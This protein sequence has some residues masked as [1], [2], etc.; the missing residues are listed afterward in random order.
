L[1]SIWRSFRQGGNTK[2]EDWSLEELA[3]ALGFD[4]EKQV[5][6][7][8]ESYQFRVVEKDGGKKYL[9]LNSVTGK[10][11]PEPTVRIPAQQFSDS[12]VEVKRCGRTLSALVNGLS[13]KAAIQAGMIMNN[14]ET[15]EDQSESS[16]FV[17]GDSDDE[18]ELRFVDG[19]S[20]SMG[21]IDR[22]TMENATSL[23]RTFASAL[24]S[25]SIPTT[26]IET[27]TI[28]EATGNSINTLLMPPSAASAP[29]F[30]FS[31]TPPSQA[32]QTPF[33]VSQ[34]LQNFITAAS[35][36][37]PVTL[38]TSAPSTI[39]TNYTMVNEQGAPAPNQGNNSQQG[40]PTSE[41]FEHRRKKGISIFNR[42]SKLASSL[43]NPRKHH[44]AVPQQQQAALQ[45]Q[46]P[47]PDFQSQLPHIHQALHQQHQSFTP[48]QQAALEQQRPL[49]DFQSQLPQ[50]QQTLQQQQHP[51][52]QQ[53][54]PQPPPQTPL[55]QLSIPPQ[56]Q[57][58]FLPEQIPLPE[59]PP[60][61]Q[62]LEPQQIPLP[63]SP[64]K[65]QRSLPQQQATGSQSGKRKITDRID[66]AI[67]ADAQ[68]QQNTAGPSE[69][70][71]EHRAKRPMFNRLKKS[72]S[73]PESNLPPQQPQSVLQQQ[74]PQS[75]LQ[76][77]QSVLQQQQP[78]SVIQP[79]QSDLQQQQPQ[80]IL[81]QPQSIL[82]QQQ[83]QSVFQPPQSD[84]QQQQQQFVQQPQTDVQ[85]QSFP[86]QQQADPQQ[87]QSVLQQPQS[88][89]QQPQSV[90]Q[91]QQPF[92]QQPFQQQSFQQQPFQ[93]Q[94]FQQQPFQQQPFQQQSF[95]QQPFQQQPFQQQPFQ[96]QPFQQ[97]PFQQQPFQ[98]QPFQQ[99]PFQQQP[100]QQQPFQQQPF[101][102]QPFQQQSSQQQPLQQQPFQQQPFQQQSVL[103]QQP[104]TQD[105]VDVPFE[106]AED[107]PPAPQQRPPPTLVFAHLGAPGSAESLSKYQI[108]PDNIFGY[109]AAPAPPQQ[110]PP[111]QHATYLQDGGLPPQQQPMLNT[112]AP[113][114]T[115]WNQQQQPM[116]N[117]AAPQDAVWNQQ[118][119]PMLNAAAPQDAVWNPQQQQPILNVVAPQDAV[120]NPQQPMLNA[121]APQDVAWN[122]QQQPML[123]AVAPQDTAWNQQQQPMLDAAAPQD[124]V[125]NQQQQPILNAAAP[126]D[127]VW[128]PQQQTSQ[129]QPAPT[130][131]RYDQYQLD[132][133]YAK[134]A[135]A[136]KARK[137]L[138]AEKASREKYKREWME[139]Y[140][141]EK[142]AK[143]KVAAEKAAAAE[144]RRQQRL[145]AEREIKLLHEKYQREKEAAFKIA[146]PMRKDEVQE[147]LGRQ[148][149]LDLSW[150]VLPTYI[151]HVTR[152]LVKQE[153]LDF[154]DEQD[155]QQA[156]EFRRHS[157]AVR[158][159]HRWYRNA[160]SMRLRRRGQLYR[161]RAKE[162]IKQKSQTPDSQNGNEALK[163]DT[164]QA[165]AV[166]IVPSLGQ[167]QIDSSPNNRLQIS[168][169]S[170]PSEDTPSRNERKRKSD[171]Q[172]HGGWA[173]PSA[174]AAAR[175]SSADHKV[176]RMTG[177]VS[178]ALSTAASA[179]SA[180]DATG[181]P[182]I[183]LIRGHPRPD[184][185][186][187]TF[188]NPYFL[189]KSHG[190]YA[191]SRQTLQREVAKRKRATED[192]PNQT[193]QTSCEPDSPPENKRR[194]SETQM[195]HLRSLSS[196]SHNSIQ[197]VVQ[198]F[199]ESESW[200]RRTRD[201]LQQGQGLHGTMSGSSTSPN[202]GAGGQSGPTSPQSVPKYRSRQSK[203]VS[204]KALGGRMMG[205]TTRSREVTTVSRQEE[206]EQMQREEAEVAAALVAANRAENANGHGYSHS[207]RFAALAQDDDAEVVDDE[208]SEEVYGEEYQEMTEAEGE[209]EGEATEDD[210]EIE[211]VATKS[212]YGTGTGATADDAI[213]LDSD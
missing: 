52:Q 96:Q 153:M 212:N 80:S 126:Q 202:A 90:L 4:E 46:H 91:Q 129:V 133:L 1:Q 157:L 55:G 141:A 206:E 174:R 128:N 33:N 186:I 185:K 187:S 168:T 152:Q 100:F 192:D 38:T 211:I 160:R 3:D 86:Q 175:P 159:F 111:T 30:S 76:Q 31:V 200:Y 89:F 104:F 5:Q 16:L 150:G 53:P 73:A 42:M 184:S 6:T 60:R 69:Q 13:T 180:P 207:N 139:R 130:L 112:V 148:M 23:R 127:A 101:Q 9:D 70:S 149:A 67:V 48:Q 75:T 173:Q 32:T 208:E 92:Q 183:D 36:T 176:S 154:E 87:P 151:Y 74:Q 20:A 59:S 107:I 78:Q 120:W 106:N 170:Q 190:I 93:Q 37:S 18:G 161:A 203:F 71:E 156:D 162:I 19:L 43:T 204:T 194:A 50:I 113:Q 119:Q 94:P 143:E 35:G 108:R 121:A 39:A 117:A 41:Q 57:Q 166:Q 40:P 17:P 7:F 191:P 122:Q 195:R 14:Q 68:S 209:I 205:A 179:L 189:F 65:K 131:T 8:V 26:T 172:N 115:A 22:S 109:L 188:K 49:P 25:T 102:Q 198:E 123:N 169:T 58:P 136:E 98:Q 84:L 79:Q 116:L 142:A 134:I 99:Q 56:Q 12:I 213:E 155:R 193:S 10:I 66:H 138:E 165:K 146:E 182:V 47:L 51:Q 158:Y 147:Y 178:P 21:T 72:S 132:I 201:Q 171:L 95:Q 135:T 28:H 27:S 105:P 164:K 167:D 145:A 85:Q 11:F 118:Q 62:P 140:A 97:Q 181:I 83:P 54:A 29:T 82:Q 2:S 63:E 110:E 61:Q 137:D 81:Q 88:V 15:P 103:Q 34:S 114:D 210:E 125:W 144:E 45:Q 24:T 197:R 196:E 77:P 64:P 177:A 199:E 44:H 124:A 163:A